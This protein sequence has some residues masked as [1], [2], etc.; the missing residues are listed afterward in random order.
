M[1]TDN[2]LIQLFIPII[3]NELL[4][5]GFDNVV[6]QQ[7]NQPTQQGIPTA[8]TVYF[9]KTHTRRY[10]FLGRHD[11]WDGLSNRMV[12]NE[13]QYY[14]TT[15]RFQFLVLQNVKMPA[16]TAAD[17]A[18]EVASILQSDKTLAILNAQKV[19]VLRITD[20]VNPYFT[21]DRDNFEALPSFDFVMLY[22][23]DRISANPIVDSFESGIYRV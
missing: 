17:L 12:H 4:I 21:D 9:Y 5:D 3:Q 6:V 15:F 20:I 7:A 13:R 16:Y 23:N 10:G 14:E 22:L 18:D 11:N 8:P 19:G 1:Q 2:T